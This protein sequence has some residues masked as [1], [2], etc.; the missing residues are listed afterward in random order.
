MEDLDLNLQDFVAR[1]NSDLIG[2]YINI[3][4]RSA[5][6]LIKRF[7]GEISDNAM[8]H[9]LLKEISSS[10]DKIALL[11]ENREFAK[12]IRIIMDLTDKVNSFVDEH[13]PWEIAKH[14]EQEA[15]LQTICSIT[16]EAFRQLSIYLK[17]VLP[18]VALGVE[19]FLSIPEMQWNDIDTPLSSK[20]P[21][22]SYKHLMSRV[23]TSQIDGLL[24]ANLSK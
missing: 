6:F 14:P 18:Q 11:Y 4:S 10:K 8:G 15:N 2:K 20:N 21:I 12:A 7:N 23:E 1:V 16:L 3:A 24:A 17:P 19:K 9:P 13:K 5:G 22:Q